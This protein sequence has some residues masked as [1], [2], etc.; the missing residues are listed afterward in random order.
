MKIILPENKSEITLSQYQRYSNL[1]DKDI[2][3]FDKAIEKVCIFTKLKK[4]EAEALQYKDLVAIS[5][6]IDVALSQD[7]KFQN[8]FKINDVEF[9]FINL[10]KMIGSEYIDLVSYSKNLEDTGNY[11]K[12]I[13]ILFRPIIDK[14]LGNTY[15]VE[16]YNGTA[17]YSE[18][19][20][21]TPLSIVDGMLGFFLSLR[22]ELQSY[23][24][25][26]TDKAQQRAKHHK[27]ISSNGDGLQV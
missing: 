5:N 12:L 22:N 16:K 8:R 4:V 15:T 10:D 18:I 11:H 14:G 2:S 6:Q 24:Q 19:M 23:I 17:K 26:F 20:K 1:I 21:Q 7:C 3:D 25:Q 13:A 9:G 27:V